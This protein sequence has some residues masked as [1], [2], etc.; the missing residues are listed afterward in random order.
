M[1]IDTREFQRASPADVLSLSLSL[2]S[3]GD[4]FFSLF[5]AY[6]CMYLYET[7]QGAVNHYVFG[8]NFLRANFNDD[9]NELGLAVLVARQCHGFDV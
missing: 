9:A 8:K 5:C 7:E 1:Y 3:S 2:H 6:G 4:I